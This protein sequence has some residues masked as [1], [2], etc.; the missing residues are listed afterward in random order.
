MTIMAGLFSRRDGVEPSA[1]I[2]AEITPLLS[3]YP[4]D[5]VV[6]FADERVWLAKVD[7]GAFG[8]SGFHRDGD[9]SVAMLTGEPLLDDGDGDRYRD[10]IR[11]HADWTAGDW[12][13]TARTRGV[14]AAASYVPAQ[15]RL[16]I[17]TDR[18]GLRGLYLLVRDEF[19]LFTTAFRIIE[20]L[21]SIRKT[22]DFQA[23]GEQ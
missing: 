22:P 14:F 10:L 13:S 8:A 1:E 2:R 9:G 11:L 7:I 16:T 21:R 5:T 6:E 4:G 20:A 23:V 17:V 18:L 19:I 15:S 3:R 12:R